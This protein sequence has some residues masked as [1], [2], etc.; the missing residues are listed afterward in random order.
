MDGQGLKAWREFMGLK[1]SDVA[2]M[3]G[4]TVAEVIQCEGGK[5]PVP[6]NIAK[7]PGKRD[8]G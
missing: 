5:K 3:F 6:D 2:Q 7:H 1:Y 8:N 4:V